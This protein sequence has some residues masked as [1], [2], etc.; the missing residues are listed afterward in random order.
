MVDKALLAKEEDMGQVLGAILINGDLLYDTSYP[1][2]AKDFIRE[3]ALVFSCVNNMVRK[4]IRQ[5]DDDMILNYI[6]TNYPTWKDVYI[7]MYPDNDFVKN[8]MLTT[9]SFNF[10]FHYN[11]IRKMSYLRDLNEM[12][13]D[14]SKL[15]D[16][17]GVDEQLNKSFE[18]MTLEDIITK[19][20]VEFNELHQNW[21]QGSDEDESLS[22]ETVTDE[23]L[24]DA[25]E[26]NME[27]G[28]KFPIGLEVLTHIFRGQLPQKYHLN[29]AGSGVG[30]IKNN[31]RLG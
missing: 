21:I 16:V 20:K 29:M 12:N 6:K 7:E 17:D 30:K 14:I 11:N 28:H 1:I 5:F 22:S 31:C 8:L 23:Y 9:K 3:Y 15:Y 19:V 24:D 13:Y 26:G 10:P 4:G 18:K 25:L 27:V 2:E